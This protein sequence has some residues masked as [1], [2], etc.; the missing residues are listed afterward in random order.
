MIGIPQFGIA[1]G[2]LGAVIALMGLFPGVT[3]IQ[4]GRGIGVLQFVTIQAGFILLIMGAILYVTFTFYDG[5]PVN[6]AQRISVR[7]ALTGLI[8]SAMAGLS[9]VF[10]FGSHLPTPTSEAFFG[11]LQALGTIIG[12]GVAALGVLL[13]AALGTPPDDDSEQTA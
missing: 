6:F 12:F 8:F 5:R 11:P 10:G 13:Y 9:D 7:L 1:L 2:A 3:G 4:P